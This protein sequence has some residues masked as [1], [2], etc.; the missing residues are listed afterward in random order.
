MASKGSTRPG[1]RLLMRSAL[2]VALSSVSLPAVAVAALGVEGGARAAD[3]APGGSCDDA[4]RLVD[5]GEQQAAVTLIRGLRASRQ[6]P[7]TPVAPSGPTSPPATGAPPGGST[8]A[9]GGTASSACASEYADAVAY[10]ARAVAWLQWADQL[11]AAAGDKKDDASVTFETPAPE[12]CSTGDKPAFPSTNGTAKEAHEVVKAAEQAALACDR[13][14]PDAAARNKEP[15]QKS[16]AQSSNESWDSFAK[17]QLAP[18]GPVLLGFLGWCAV[19]LVVARLLLV[20][21][22]NTTARFASRWHWRAVLLWVGWLLLVLSG[23]LGVGLVALVV[24]T[25][26][27]YAD[28]LKVF[29]GPALLVAGVVVTWLTVRPPECLD[30]GG[31]EHWSVKRWVAFVAGAL[32]G[33][34]G[35]RVLLLGTAL[36][37]PL[38]QQPRLGAL[39]GVAA[40][41]VFAVA[42]GG[43]RRLTITAKG[44][45]APTSESLRATVSR[46]APNAPHGVE[47][48][49]GTDADVLSAVGI[50]ATSST[51][52]VAALARVL[53]YAKPPTPWQL[54]ITAH[55]ADVLT[56]DLMRNGRLIETATT[57][58]RTLESLL[59]DPAAR[60]DTSSDATTS[61]GASKANDG[62]ADDS[63]AAKL[64]LAVFP[65]AL[66]VIRIATAD[67]DTPMGIGGATK[68]RSLAYQYLS[69]LQARGTHAAKAL[70]AEAVAA[71]PG[72]QLAQVGHWYA[73]YRDATGREDMQRYVIFLEGLLPASGPMPRDVALTVRVLYMRV[74]IGINLLFAPDAAGEQRLHRPSEDDRLQE[75]AKALLDAANGR[76]GYA[77]LDRNFLAAVLVNV[78]ALTASIPQGA[79]WTPKLPE[80]PEVPEAHSPD[81]N[82]SLA[83]YFATK[84]F[85]ATDPPNPGNVS[86]NDRQLAVRHLKLASVL[87]YLDAWRREDPQLKELRACAEYRKEFGTDLLTTFLGVAPFM[88]HEAQLIQAG[89]V[90]LDKVAGTTPASLHKVGMKPP[91]ASW[92]HDCAVL[93]QRIHTDLSADGTDGRPSP[94]G[95]AWYLA[96]LSVFVE[97]GR[98][99]IPTERDDVDA[100]RDD[101]ATGLKGYKG[102][103]E[104]VTRV[105][106]KVVPP[107]AAS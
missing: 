59:V 67:G 15:D 12:P 34:A 101:L 17:G 39:F 35:L 81:V 16:L 106:N 103:P 70:S 36:K 98:T 4:R 61:D 62:A 107:P 88:G 66:A 3:P 69:S 30:S 84:S 80:G 46:L 90:T 32:V 28:W 14:N 99:T 89:L 76:E 92:V 9:G 93:G 25:A 82:Y 29:S 10:Q 40:A 20:A 91:V 13:N 58:R 73:L 37:E 96:V 5:L 72:N 63:P 85:W 83:C 47:I 95:E 97:K 18:W 11:S 33:C 23:G 19:V 8:A 105:I 24:N 64:D 102:S 48:P 57:Q 7:L 2:M 41:V 65:A 38:T 104:D 77:D 86:V 52:L 55:S 56:A 42:W 100:V 6:T 87:E 27:G 51:P 53:T 45:G 22:R 43:G 50:V 79:G 21:L 44:E 71:D 94:D 54:T 26:D 60:A 78:Q 74:A 49:L 31:S 75:T 68:W 1:S